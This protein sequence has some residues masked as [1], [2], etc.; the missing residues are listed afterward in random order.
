MF[1]S[2]SKAFPLHAWNEGITKRAVAKSCVLDYVESQS[3]RK[4]DTRTLNL[5]AWTRNPSDI[6]KVTWLT[7]V[8]RNIIVHNVPP[9][10]QSG[11]TFRVIVH[12]DLVEGSP[13]NEGQG[14]TH[15]FDWRLGVVDGKSAPRDR[16]DPSPRRNDHHRDDGDNDLR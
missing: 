5:W 1:V 7:I 16:H 6:P 4:E 10:G 12:L 13:G 3:L 15:V 14:S 8:G 9:A 2:A 11:L